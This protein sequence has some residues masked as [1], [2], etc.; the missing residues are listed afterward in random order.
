MKR[1][2]RWPLLL[3]M[4]FL[5][6]FCVTPAFAL[7]PNS[8]SLFGITMPDIRF[9]VSRDPDQEETV[10]EGERVFYT[11]FQPA[12]FEAFGKYTKAAGL[13]LKSQTYQDRT[14]TVELEK[15]GAIITF[16]Y[17]YDEKKASLLYPTGVRKEDSK[18]SAKQSDSLLPDVKKTFGAV[19]PSLQSL[20]KNH[21]AVKTYKRS[22]GTDELRYT[23]ITISDY[24]SIN[25]Y[26]TE[27][28]CVVENSQTAGNVLT[29]VLKLLDSIFTCQYDM[30]GQTFSFICPE[31]YYVDPNLPRTDTADKLILPNTDEAFGAILPRISSAILR[32]PDKKETH[33]DGS[34]N[35]IYERFTEE[36]YNVFSAYLLETNCVVGSY[37]ID[38]TG[39]LVIPLSLKDQEFVFTYDQVNQRGIT[40]YPK[41]A[42]IESEIPKSSL[43]TAIP[44]ATPVPTPTLEPGTTP[45]PSHFYSVNEA[46]EKVE[47]YFWHSIRWNDPDSIK[48]YNHTWIPSEDG[49]TFLI[50]Y[51]GKNRFGGTVRKTYMIDINMY[52]LEIQ[53]AYDN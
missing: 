34:L 33:E 27:I 41:G 10:P 9:A 17:N 23:E 48:V 14:L 29:V 52:T 28:G 31:L 37:Y 39:A 47:Y 42:I 3:L 15:D 12:D 1:G 30:T 50:D 40:T 6:F 4:I 32:Y 25:T 45:K 16:Q 46:W 38:S 36:E 8:D 19:I 26:L 18:N 43:P 53:F 20:L 5:S 13:T 24:N 44:T 51:S 7:F 11:S 35:E 49:Y 21:P 22:N 2:N